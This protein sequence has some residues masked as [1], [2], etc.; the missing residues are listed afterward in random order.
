VVSPS[1]SPRDKLFIKDSIP[2]LPWSPEWEACHGVPW[3]DFYR[4]VSAF[5][6][7]L[8][9]LFSQGS[10]SAKPAKGDH[11]RLQPRVSFFCSDS[12]FIH[13]VRRPSRTRRKQSLRAPVIGNLKVGITM[14]GR[15]SLP[16]CFNGSI[17]YCYLM[18]QLNGYLGTI[19]FVPLKHPRFC[20][21]NMLGIFFSQFKLKN[22]RDYRQH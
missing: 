20:L 19:L 7:G 21:F 14:R 15:G 13:S 18:E 22:H 2:V 9:P 3:E 16:F 12:S 11:E 8:P 6:L 1:P 10:P 4:P 17:G 5:P